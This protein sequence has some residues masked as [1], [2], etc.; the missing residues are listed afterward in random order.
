MTQSDNQKCGQ[1]VFKGFIDATGIR[2][3]DKSCIPKRSLEL[4]TNLNTS[5][6]NWSKNDFQNQADNTM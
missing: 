5:N 2:D 4:R 6:Y 3:R 1:S